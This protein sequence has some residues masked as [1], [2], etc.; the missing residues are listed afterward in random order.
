MVNVEEVQDQIEQTEEIKL[1]LPESLANWKPRTKLGKLVLEGKI[2]SIDEILEKNLKIL[3]PEIVDILLPNLKIEPV[4][5]GKGGTKG[6]A[7]K[8]I[9]IKR[10]QK[11]TASG[12]RIRYSVMVI[13]GDE[14]GHVGIGRGKAKDGRS[15]YL[16][17]VRKAKL[18]IIKVYRGCGSWECWCKEEH[19]IPWKTY[20]KSGSVKVI[21][22]PAPKG[23]GLVVDDESKKLLRLAGIKDVWSKT[24]GRTKQHM[25]LIQAMFDALK[26]I[27]KYKKD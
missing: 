3:E 1:P 4:L 6:G 5:I 11:V 2:K 18:N 14:N 25:N 10:S 7:G 24:F 20:G 13:V 12:R 23:T 17:A 15:A 27:P 21:L 8:R 16:K 26:N 9:P 22:I 19:S